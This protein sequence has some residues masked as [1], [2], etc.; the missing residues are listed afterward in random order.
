[1]AQKKKQLRFPKGVV[2]INFP[3]RGIGFPKQEWV[4]QEINN[5]KSMYSNADRLFWSFSFEYP[6]TIYLIKAIK[7][8]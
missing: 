5:I 7:H 6:G 2:V 4:Q 3:I 1:M 8:F